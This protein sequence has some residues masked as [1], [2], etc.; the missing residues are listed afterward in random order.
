MDLCIE[1]A[2]P[3]TAQQPAPKR[4]RPHNVI[5]WSAVPDLMT[6][7]PAE[8]AERIGCSVQAVNAARRRVRG[9][10][11]RRLLKRCR[12]PPWGTTCEHCH[13]A[14][15]EHRMSG[16]WVCDRCLLAHGAH[17]PDLLSERSMQVAAAMVV[18]RTA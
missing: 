3:T 4:R 17:D 11:L 16:H 1:K 7:T 12:T 5:N 9:Y 13:A 2:P 10:P 8:L 6:A 15:A 14:V 18:R